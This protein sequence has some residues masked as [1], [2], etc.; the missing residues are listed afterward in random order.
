MFRRIGTELREDVLSQKLVPALVMGLISAVNLVIFCFSVGISL[1]ENSLGPNAISVVGFLLFGSLVGCLLNSLFSAY[2]GSTVKPPIAPLTVLSGVPVTLGLGLDTDV[3]LITLAAT[4]GTSTIV[5]GIFFLLIGK[6][7]LTSMLRFIPYSVSGGFLAGAGGI[8]C[9]ITLPL[10]G[11]DTDTLST[12]RLIEPIVILTWLPGLLLGIG[13]FWGSQRWQ[14]GLFLSGSVLTAILI[15]HLV[16]HFADISLTEARAT[17]LMLS[18][19]AETHFWPLF[20]LGDLTKISWGLVA[21]QTPTLLLVVFLNAV[22]MTLYM[23]SLEL[24][25]GKE[26]DWDRE[27]TVSGATALSCALGASPATC[28]AVVPTT[29]H[30][31][32]GADTRLTGLFLVAIFAIVLAFGARIINLIPAPV[33]GAVLL[34]NGIAI[35]HKWVLQA[36]RRIPWNEFAIII[37]IFVSVLLIGFVEAVGIGMLT[38]TALFIVRLSS[39]D[40]IVG[41]SSVRNYQSRRQRSIPDQLI[42]RDE[43]TRGKIYTL[44]GYVFFGSAHSLFRRLTADLT[45]SHSVCIV[46]DLHQVSGFDFSAVNSFCGFLNKAHANGWLVILSRA[47]NQV[48]NLLLESLSDDVRHSLILSLDLDQAI[49]R[50]EDEV[51]HRVKTEKRED[52]LRDTLMERAIEEMDR[53]LDRQTHFEQIIEK[54]EDR[55]E[56]RRYSK[57][58]RI[59]S[60]ESLPAGLQFLVG[61]QASALDPTGTRIRQ[62]RPGD[63]M[64]PVD[65]FSHEETLMTVVADRPCTVA[66]LPRKAQKYLEESDEKLALEL[67]RYLISNTATMELKLIRMSINRHVRTGSEKNQQ[68]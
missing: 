37:V 58:D 38:A 30:K 36:R 31:I 27:F 11:I 57:G 16:F 55:I 29:R 8:L 18:A 50:C 67:Y 44:R 24:S 25:I 28:I 49:E 54:L 46:I 1:F 26:V 4:I 64:N 32:F 3:L 61:G 17:G 14:G 7:H 41:S 52:S 62:F 19:P 59:S 6:L 35:L 60:P 9:L 12:S 56:T 13:F 21:D 66:T 45:A 22:L 5:T 43:G 48:K 33:V 53:Q 68:P 39:M 23:A 34:Y 20:D 2:R 40:P 63:T 51:I 65:A 42:L 10:I 15:Y 47:K